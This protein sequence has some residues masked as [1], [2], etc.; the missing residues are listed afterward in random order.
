MKQTYIL[1]AG[2]IAIAMAL[3]T[4]SASSLAQDGGASPG[5]SGMDYEDRYSNLPEYLRPLD[6]S[7]WGHLP[8]TQ[9][10][11]DDMRPEPRGAQGP[12]R[13]AGDMES[14]GSRWDRAKSYFAQPVGNRGELGFLEWRESN[15]DTP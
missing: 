12:R 1:K 13:S 2:G 4:F 6:H 8:R 11:D 5:L 15:T 7:P 10:R 3:S 14:E 9:Y